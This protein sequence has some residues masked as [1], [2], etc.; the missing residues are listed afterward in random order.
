MRIAFCNVRRVAHNEIKLL[1]LQSCKPIGLRC[2]CLDEMNW[3]AKLGG[4]G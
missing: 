2:V 4:V 3:Q 1:G